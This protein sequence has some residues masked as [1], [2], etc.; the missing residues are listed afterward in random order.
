MNRSAN[1]KLTPFE[2]QRDI[3]RDCM[4]IVDDGRADWKRGEHVP[5]IA[6]SR[7]YDSHAIASD[8]RAGVRKA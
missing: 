5:T 6:F 7:T 1:A 3:R 4:R 2:L 8:D